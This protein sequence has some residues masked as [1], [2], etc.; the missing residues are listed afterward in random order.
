MLLNLILFIKTFKSLP[1]QKQT[2]NET[3]S[4]NNWTNKIETKPHYNI[5]LRSTNYFDSTFPR[6][7]TSSS[8]SQATPFINTK[9]VKESVAEEHYVSKLIGVMDLILFYLVITIF[10]YDIFLIISFFINKLEP[11]TDIYS[12]MASNST[13]HNT[14]VGIDRNS[15]G[16]SWREAF[17]YGSGALR[18]SLLRSGGTPGQRAFVIGTTV[19][20]EAA[21]KAVMNAINDPDYILAHLNSWNV[22]LNGDKASIHVDKDPDMMSKL[23]KVVPDNSDDFGLG[24]Y[25][26]KMFNTI[27]ETLKPILE[28]VHVDYSNAVLADQIYGISILLFILT[29]LVIGLLLALMLNIVILVYSDKLLNLFTNKYIRWY[30]L[31][32]KKVIGI[33]ICFLGGSILYFMYVLAYGIHFIA[34]HPIVI[35]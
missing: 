33:E 3:I 15:G 26:T 2:K 7:T 11:F 34:T 1:E 6:Y 17:I 32:N 20:S 14:N 25:T 24:D 23:N 19:I 13:T 9:L 10:L 16:I 31:F 29:I 28:P 5:P 12:Y 22:I 27:L 4:D 30:I 8:S 35:T 18:L 21:S